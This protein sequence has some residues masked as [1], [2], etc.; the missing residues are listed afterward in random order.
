MC[1]S[2]N[3]VE[4]PKRY[5]LVGRVS[6]KEQLGAPIDDQLE[7]LRAYVKEHRGVVVDEIREEGISASRANSRRL[8]NELV[9]RQ[10]ARRDVDVILFFDSSR[11]SRAGVDEV[12]RINRTVNVAGMSIQELNNPIGRNRLSGRWL[13]TR[14]GPRGERAG[15]TNVRENPFA[16]VSPVHW[17]R[18]ICGQCR[19]RSGT[20]TRTPLGL[21]QRQT[22]STRRV[23]RNDSLKAREVHPKPQRRES[24]QHH[25]LSPDNSDRARFFI[26]LQR[27]RRRVLDPPR[28]K[29]GLRA[30]RRTSHENQSQRHEGRP[31]C[32][33]RQASSGPAP[34][35]APAVRRRV[36]RADLPAP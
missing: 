25:S 3:T 21:D 36:P 28:E 19:A 10:K 6:T 9:E 16:R 31:S 12:S 32:P 4:H 7:H 5:V 17:V 22:A 33:R 29:T 35:L 26:V 15:K 18:I 34:G 27:C 1:A 11:V 20:I 30:R 14:Q 8:W 23:A 24:A 2:E 13:R